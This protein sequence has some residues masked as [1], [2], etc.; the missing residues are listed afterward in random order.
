L[1]RLVVTRSPFSSAA[2]GLRRRNG[3]RRR[4]AIGGRREGFFLS[5]HCFGVTWES[6]RISTSTVRRRQTDRSTHLDVPPRGGSSAR[7][8]DS[9]RAATDAI[10]WSRPTDGARTWE[11]G[12]HGR[13]T[14]PYRFVLRDASDTNVRQLVRAIK[15]QPLS[16][17]ALTSGFC[18]PLS[19]LL[20]QTSTKRI[21]ADGSSDCKRNP[22]R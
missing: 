11:C 4:D 1:W 21:L 19:V 12:G 2:G 6:S 13:P 5:A 16:R 18:L 20:G 17:L 14:L 7:S 22:R 9:E 3:L 15:P 10:P 8:R